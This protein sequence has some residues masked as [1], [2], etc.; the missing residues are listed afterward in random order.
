MA[1]RRNCVLPFPHCGGEKRTRSAIAFDLR[2]PYL[3]LSHLES[4]INK[5][6]RGG[7]NRRAQARGQKTWVRSGLKLAAQQLHFCFDP[8][9]RIVTD[10]RERER[11]GERER[12]ISLPAV[13]APTG[14]KPTTFWCT[15]QHPNQLQRPTRAGQLHCCVAR[16]TELLR[17][18]ICYKMRGWPIS[19]GFGKQLQSHA[20]KP[21]VSP[22]AVSGVESCSHLLCL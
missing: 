5:K 11:R 12:N 7:G 9:L 17:A 19:T 16:F 22:Q 13:H 18:S 21:P 8:L 3:P 1:A 15:G 14:T 6:S 2:W 10:F 4:L 20:H